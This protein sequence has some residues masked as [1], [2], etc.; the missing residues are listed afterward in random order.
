M[1]RANYSGSKTWGSQQVASQHHVESESVLQNSCGRRYNVNSDTY[2]SVLLF[3][4]IHVSSVCSSWS[5]AQMQI[6]VTSI[7]GNDDNA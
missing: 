6:T 7:Y 5:L 2:G 1:G 3:K 4:L